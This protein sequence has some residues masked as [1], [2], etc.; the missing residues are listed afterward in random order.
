MKMTSVRVAASIAA[1][2]LAGV[3]TGR[4][5]GNPRKLNV[6]RKASDRPKDVR[7][8]RKANKRARK[9]RRRNRG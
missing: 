2:A 4:K 6:K 3:S 9:A 7:R 5:V 8:R 1:A